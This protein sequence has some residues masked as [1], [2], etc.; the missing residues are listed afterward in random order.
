MISTANDEQNRPI[1]PVSGERILRICKR[2]HRVTTA[3]AYWRKDYGFSICRECC[4]INEKKFKAARVSAKKQARRKT[5]LLLLPEEKRATFIRLCA[6]GH[7]VTEENAVYRKRGVAGCRECERARLARF[8]S[9]PNRTLTEDQAR[10]V[11]EALNSGETVSTVVDGYKGQVVDSSGKKKHRYIGGAIC[12]RVELTNF[13]KANPKFGVIVEKLA[14]KN[15][16]ASKVRTGAARRTRPAISLRSAKGLKAAM[17]AVQRATEKLCDTI[18]DEVRG[19]MLVALA[20]G[21][22]RPADVV[23]R[24]G[25]FVALVNRGNRHSV[26]SKF[27]NLSLDAPIAPDST[28][29]LIETVTRGLWAVPA[30]QL[31]EPHN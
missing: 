9:S 14:K 2:G 1:D 20:A 26:L 16:T 7:A 21:R 11:L 4:R 15:E 13:C 12:R 19:E 17:S 28:T 24:V 31:D 27:G 23:Q 22:L 6:N 10:Q 18:R 5:G 30:D 25:E 29:T 8:R 3:N